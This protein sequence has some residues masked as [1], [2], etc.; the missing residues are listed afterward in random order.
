MALLG[1]DLSQDFLEFFPQ[2]LVDAGVTSSLWRVTQVVLAALIEA[3]VPPITLLML[4]RPSDHPCT[5]GSP[6]Q[7]DSEH[8]PSVTG[9]GDYL[10]AYGGLPPSLV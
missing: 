5:E 7:D 1:D 4:A 3:I 2:G 10:S 8:R 9:E 6:I